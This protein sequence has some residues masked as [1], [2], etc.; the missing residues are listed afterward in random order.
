MWSFNGA[1]C[2]RTADARLKAGATRVN[3]E[4]RNITSASRENNQL[5]FGAGSI[6][7]LAADELNAGALGMMIHTRK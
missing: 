7:A 5:A 4:L 1:C 3:G 2:R 6:T